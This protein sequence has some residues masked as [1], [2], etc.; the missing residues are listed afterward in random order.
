MTPATGTGLGIPRLQELEF[1]ETAMQAVADGKTYDETRRAL[2]AHMQYSR[3]GPERTGNHA[4]RRGLGRDPDDGRYFHNANECLTELM[5]LG[6]VE[7]AALPSTRKALDAYR[8]TMFNATPEGLAWARL[9]GEDVRS[10][11][12]EMLRGLWSLHPQL[13]SVVR[14]VSRG[15]FRVPTAGWNEVHGD[16]TATNDKELAAARKAYVAFLAD[17]CAGAVAAGVTGWEADRD[18]ISL[19]MNS[20]LDRL[21]ARA[22][23]RNRDAFPR[24]RDFV[25]SCEEATVAFAFEQVG[26]KVDFITV[27]I[28]RRW[29][30]SLNIASFSYHVPGPPSLS[31]WATA[32]VSEG[33]LGVPEVKRRVGPEWVEK[34]LDALP[35]QFSRAADHVGGSFAPIHMVRAALCSKVGVSEAVFERALTELLTTQHDRKRPYQVHLDP[36]SHG[37]LPPTERPF[38]FESRGRKRPFYLMSL[39][40]TTAG[41]KKP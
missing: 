7:R 19:A 39:L 34:V 24:N 17:R 22:S 40:T 29:L 37:G 26:V 2:I 14:V 41:R 5:R 13:A 4:G 18:E 1:L 6:W 20:Y 28:L 21:A 25:Q 33:P 15:S 32:E 9:V 10:A 23:S 31:F 12:D 38:L 8:E 36:A 35:G 11:Y 30:R 16:F 3:R 27:E